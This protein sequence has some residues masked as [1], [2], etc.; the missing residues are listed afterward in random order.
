MTESEVD[1]L[2]DNLMADFSILCSAKTG[3]NTLSIFHTI[4]KHDKLKCLD[5]PPAAELKLVGDDEKRS[6]KCC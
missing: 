1:A 5:S 3:E 2:A 4:A 6:K